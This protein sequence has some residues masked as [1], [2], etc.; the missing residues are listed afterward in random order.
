MNKNGN[1]ISTDEK[2]EGLNNIF[3]LVFTGNLSPPPFPVAGLQD[4]VQRG[5]TPPTVREDHVHDHLTNL[6]K[7]KSMGPDEMHRRVLR[8]LA[9]IIA[10]LPH[11]GKVVAVR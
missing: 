6:N 5:K 3:I 7:H 2:A 8:E 11:I 10:P 1:V 4:G 9:E